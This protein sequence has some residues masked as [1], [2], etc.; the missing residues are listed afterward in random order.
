M[1]ECSGRYYLYFMLSV[2]QCC[3]TT[4]AVLVIVTYPSVFTSRKLSLA[5]HRNEPAS[6][7]KN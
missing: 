4:T 7:L 2:N 5:L 6:C 3:D 1:E